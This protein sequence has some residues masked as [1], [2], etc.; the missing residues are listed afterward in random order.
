MASFTKSL[1]NPSYLHSSLTLL[2]FFMSWGIWWSFFQLWLTKDTASGGLGL[3]GADVGTV[4]SVNSLVT[5][6]LMFFYG[7][8][9]DRL[10]LKRHLTILIG[11]IA[12]CV[13]AFVIFVYEPLLKNAFMFGVIL[14]SIVLSAGFMAGVGLLEAFAERMSRRFDF[15]YGQSRMWGSFGYAVVALFA[16][17]L[18]TVNPHLNFILG[19]VFGIALLLIQLFWKPAKVDHS[20][21]PAETTQPGVREMAGLLGMKSLWLIIVFVIFSWTFYTVFDQQMFP[22]FY[23][24]LFDTKERG[25]Q[26]YGVLNAAQVFCEAAMMGVVPI[27]M[28]KIGVRNTLMLGVTVMTLRIFGC[29]ALSNPVAVSFVKMFHALEVPLFILPVFRYFTLHFNPALSATLYM[30][31]FQISAQIGNVI[32]SNP[33]G[34]LRDA[35][36][37]QPTFFVISGIVL[38]AGIYAFFTLKK[39]DEQV[40]GDPFVRDGQMVVV[41][42]ATAGP[43]PDADTGKA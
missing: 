12:S 2:L 39:D 16:G 36:G 24:G 15:E 5:L 29:A 37:Y 38:L 8:I 18:F 17:F 9:Q 13:A 14:G 10:G 41:D 43:A 28:R 32:L 19:T 22:D 23:T 7:T 40:L 27:I 11:A 21:N 33:L 30:V 1:K 31:G 35:M 42:T 3:N 34:K 25:E 20:A 6:I 4:Y 26:V